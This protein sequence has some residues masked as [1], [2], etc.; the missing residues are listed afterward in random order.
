VGWAELRAGV[1][2]DF[3]RTGNVGSW[4]GIMN[5]FISFCP[6]MEK[7]TSE[8]ERYIDY[9]IINYERSEISTMKEKY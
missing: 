1:R 5:V 4:D 3:L 6:N 9:R 8:S 7:E 2:G